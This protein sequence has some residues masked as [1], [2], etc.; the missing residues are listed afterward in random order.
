MLNFPGNLGETMSGNG[1]IFCVPGQRICEA[2]SNIISGDGT[3][4]FNKYIYASLAGQVRIE[5]RRDVQVVKVRHNNSNVSLCT[6]YVLDA[7]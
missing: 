7:L 4:T 6:N 3:Y 5:P 1:H 2:S